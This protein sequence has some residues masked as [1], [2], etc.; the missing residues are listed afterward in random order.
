MWEQL[1][2][3]LVD[4]HI[5]WRDLLDERQRKGVAWAELY[6]KDEWRFGA[7]SHNNMLTIAKMA[8]MLDAVQGNITIEVDGK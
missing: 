8:E 6:A 4:G 3:T 5:N 7:D 1:K 2:Q